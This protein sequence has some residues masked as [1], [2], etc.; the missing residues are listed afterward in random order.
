MEY[1]KF[2]IAPFICA[3]IGWFTNYLA[4]KM[5]FH[6]RRP[7]RIFFWNLQGIFPKRQKE[8]ASSLGDL[9]ESELISHNDIQQVIHDPEFR[10]KFKKII[11]NYFHNFITSK[12]TTLHPM[13]AV[14]LNNDTLDAIQKLLSQ[15]IDKYLP[16]I[17]EKIAL[18]LKNN[19]NFKEVVK[20]KVE[21]FSMDKLETILFTIMK[22]E[23]RFIEAMG[24]VLG[25]TIGIFQSIFIFLL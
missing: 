7:V 9:V 8:L 19:L 12:I 17:L 18:H 23:F 6:P 21:N 1:T 22:K 24:A 4:V 13:V 3:L 20:L 5:L 16:Q 25:F 10:A 11:Q 14:F 15:E 2:F